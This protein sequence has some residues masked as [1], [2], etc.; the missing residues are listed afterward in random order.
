MTKRFPKHIGI[1]PDGNRRWARARAL[2]PGEGYA[3]GIQPGF[4]L[5]ARCI[6]LGIEEVSVYGFT[7]ENTHRPPEQKAAFTD[8]C[9]KFVEGAIHHGIALAVIGDSTSRAFPHALLPYA[10]CRT[11]GGIRVN[12]LINYG[13]EWDIRQAIA[14]GSK[15]EAKGVA[16]HDLLGSHLVSRVDLVVRWGGCQRLSGFLP[17]QTTYADYSFIPD[18]WPDYQPDQFDQALRWYEKQDVTLGG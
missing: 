14:R 10:N 2:K 3:A 17:V 5:M 6:E 1:I 16:L 9:V 12:M 11:E 4:D 18:L 15:P 7:H 13:W 8:A